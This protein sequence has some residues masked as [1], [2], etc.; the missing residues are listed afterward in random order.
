MYVPP[1]DPR[2]HALADLVAE[3]LDLS[4]VGARDDLFE[5]GL[6]SLRIDQLL[7]AVHGQLGVELAPRELAAAPSIEA[8]AR[9]IAR[10]E[11][12]GD[13][14]RP[15]RH[16]GS[17]APF[18][19]VPGADYAIHWLVP[20]ARQ[21]GRP[22]YSF[23]ARG[24]DR[25]ALPDRTVQRTAARFVRGLRRIQPE[26]P[27]L[28]GGYSFGGAIAL[29]MAHQLRAAGESVALLALLDPTFL[30]SGFGDRM[31]RAIAPTGGAGPIPMAARLIRQIGVSVR[32]R[33][34][35]AT[36]GVLRR[37]YS[38]QRRLYF[39]LSGRQGRRYRPKPYDGSAVLVRSRNRNR[40]GLIDITH[41]LAGGWQELVVPGNH[42][43]MLQEPNAATVARLLQQAFEAAEA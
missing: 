40:P 21:L 41:L 19:C 6:D 35:V 10:A 15:V 34:R 24:F 27:Y 39:E 16:V 11:V 26:G 42:I 37:P 8:L 17:G 22:T 13:V 1:R 3:V 43:T 23:L 38:Q 18:F 28:L 20:L 2:E 14:V 33:A 9:L 25:R 30:P 31:R 5:L 4:R 32:V 29:E 36:A 12:G 7:V